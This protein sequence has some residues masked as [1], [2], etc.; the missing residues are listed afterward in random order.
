MADES[1]AHADSVTPSPPPA[2]KPRVIEIRLEDE[3]RLEERA[4][5]HAD[6]PF[7]QA[8]RVTDSQGWTAFADASIPDRAVSATQGVPSLNEDLTLESARLL[9]A[10]LN[11]LGANWG[12]V[13]Q[14]PGGPADCEAR[15]GKEVLLIQVTRA[16]TE[17]SFWKTVSRT[18]HVETP[19]A[20]PPAWADA[21]W[22]SV[23]RK[24]T[25][26]HEDVVLAVNAI[27]TPVYILGAVVTDF[28]RRYAESARAVG[29]RELWIVGP[30]SEYVYR[31][32]VR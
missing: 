20:D 7:S 23:E 21:L 9:V 27:R 15:D 10:H 19:P 4:I 26:A 24:R 32:D 13:K 16:E 30:S 8:I 14:L 6:G 5:T 31:L 12:D 2:E 28:R 25:R 11:S 29:F 18:G 22:K 3:M 17:G 1:P